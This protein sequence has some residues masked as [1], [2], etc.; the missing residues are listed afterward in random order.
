[1]AWIAALDGRVDIII[2]IIIIIGKK[3]D[4]MLLVV[5]FVSLSRFLRE[6]KNPCFS[7]CETFGSTPRRMG[8]V[9]STSTFPYYFLWY[10]VPHAKH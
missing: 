6:N 2:I 7:V 3:N 4:L 5:L 10:Y 8:P 1:M 9:Q